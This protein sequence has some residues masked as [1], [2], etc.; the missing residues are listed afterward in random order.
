[1]SGRKFDSIK[2]TQ[3]S[4]LCELGSLDEYLFRPGSWTRKFSRQMLSCDIPQNLWT[5]YTFLS[6]GDVVTKLW[7][8]EF[9]TPDMCK[10]F[11]N[12]GLQRRVFEDFTK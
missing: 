1:M 11:K 4:G 8:T 9:E 2:I 3:F 7:E 12:P 6:C 5:H 10:Q